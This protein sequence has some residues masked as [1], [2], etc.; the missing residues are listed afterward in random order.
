MLSQQLAEL[1]LYEAGVASLDGACFG[2]HG[3]GYLRFSY[4]N[5]LANIEEALARIQ[6]VSARWA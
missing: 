3:T 6:K 5:S 4:A 2:E 1:L